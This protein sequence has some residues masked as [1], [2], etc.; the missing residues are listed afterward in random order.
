MDGQVSRLIPTRNQQRLEFCSPCP[1]P[2]IANVFNRTVIPF[3]Q[4]TGL[5]EEADN[6]WVEISEWVEAGQSLTQWH[7]TV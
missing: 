4:V 2:E 1:V 6:C 5:L 7:I 3:H